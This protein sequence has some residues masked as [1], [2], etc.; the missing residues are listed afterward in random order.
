LDELAGQT[1]CTAAQ[2]DPN[3]LMG[4][5]LHLGMEGLELACAKTKAG[6]MNSF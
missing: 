3:T 2:S 5:G 4:C 1:T 6:F